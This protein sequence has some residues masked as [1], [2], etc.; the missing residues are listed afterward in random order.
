M[1]RMLL[2]VIFGF[3]I[4]VMISAVLRIFR[5]GAPS[6]ESSTKRPEK[7]AGGETMVKDP[8]CGTYLPQGDAL[9]ARIDGREEFFCSETCRDAYRSRPDS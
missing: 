7:S 5:V 9:R 6:T 8:E 4:Y 2:L 1:I 3:L